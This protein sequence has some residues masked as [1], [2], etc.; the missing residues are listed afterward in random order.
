MTDVK[1]SPK[2]DF[3][4]SV[5]HDYT[6]RLWDS[7]TGECLKILHGHS[8]W[9]WA[10]AFHPHEQILASG[11]QDETIRLWDITTGECLQILRS[12][13]PYEG[14]NIQGV[15]GLSAAQKATLKILGAVE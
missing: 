3:V 8:N 10:I 9:V 13:R 15:T 7:Q 1:F 14:M 5:S 12:P 4:A 11:S 2:G 6:I